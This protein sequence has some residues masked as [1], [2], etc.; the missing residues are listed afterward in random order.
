LKSLKG[1]K[2]LGDTSIDGNNIKMDI[3]ETA[4]EGYGLD[5][6]SSG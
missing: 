5:S 1:K 6:F 2:L 4:Y 3:K